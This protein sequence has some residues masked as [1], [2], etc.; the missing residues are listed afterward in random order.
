MKVLVTGSQGQ[1][2]QCLIKTLQCDGNIILFPFSRTEL[3]ITN[4]FELTRLINEIHPDVIINAAAYT[5]VDKAEDDI[6]SSYDI[7]YIATKNLAIIS[8]KLDILFLHISTDYVFDGLKSG[9]YIESDITNPINIYGKSKLAGEKAI[10]ET[11]SH[12]AILRTSWVFGEYGNNFVKTMLRLGREKKELNIIGDQIGGP[13]Y[14]GDIANA[15]VTIMNTMIENK[16]S[17]LSGV[18]HFSGYPFVSWYDFADFI[19]MIAKENDILDG[20]PLLNKIPTTEYPL[21]AERPKNSQLN[22]EK[23]INTFNLTPSNW[24][25]ALKKIQDY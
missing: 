19:F 23:I 22:C 10:Q 13:T 3:D 1:V 20:I 7:N 11:C 6:E 2:G 21:P 12:Y 25:V 18:Y 16:N 14:A 24:K 15:L 17:S 5:H 4:N 9:P 8:K